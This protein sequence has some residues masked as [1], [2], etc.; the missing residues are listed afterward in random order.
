MDEVGSDVEVIRVGRK[1]VWGLPEGQ[2]ILMTKTMYK[3]VEIYAEYEPI[4]TQPLKTE[5][6]IEELKQI[7]E[8][9]LKYIFCIVLSPLDD[10]TDNNF[11]NKYNLEAD[12]KAIAMM[13]VDMKQISIFART[14][15][16]HDAKQLISD[17]MTLVHE[18]GHLIDYK[19]GKDN[20]AISDSP[21]W[22]SAME[23]DFEIEK[24]EDNLP[25]YYVSIW[26]DKPKVFE[27]ILQTRLYFLYLE[28]VKNGSK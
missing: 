22:K 28:K 3:N 18:M 7:D 5:D 26:S 16:R 12:D 14:C 17:Q 19:M 4:G 20:K 23:E 8:K 1:Y 21:E 10:L 2:T 6:I 13:S 25:T 27:K 24:T 11:K 9:L 15:N